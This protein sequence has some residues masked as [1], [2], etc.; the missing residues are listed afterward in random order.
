MASSLRSLQ[1]LYCQ[2]QLSISGYVVLCPTGQSTETP[3]PR[4]MCPP[5][6]P[7]TQLW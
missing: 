5:S 4:G 6:V 1:V 7:G 3:L 2:L